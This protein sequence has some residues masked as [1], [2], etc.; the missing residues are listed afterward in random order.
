MVNVSKFVRDH[1]PLCVCTLGTAILGYLG[2][3]A[4]QWIINKCHKTEEID[5]VAQRT[6]STSSQRVSQSN[7]HD[8]NPQILPQAKVATQSE[9]VPVDEISLTQQSEDQ[10]PLAATKIQNAFRGHLARVALKQMQFE[11]LERQK[12]TATIKIQSVF[13]AHLAQI[14]FKNE[15]RHLLSYSLY[16]QAKPLIDE[17]EKLR[18]LPTADS[19]RTRVYL[20]NDLPIVLKQSGSPENRKRFDKMKEARKI[21]DDNNYSCLVIPTAR[22]HGNFII[23]SRL[24][25][26]KNHDTKE[27]IGFYLDHLA[28]FTEAVEEFTS[29]LCQSE[30]SD[31]TGG[32]NDAYST[33][34]TVPIGRYDNVAMYLEEGDGKLGLIDL[35][36]FYP[37][38]KS[39]QLEA[40][41]ACREAV[42]LFPHHLDAIINAANKFDPKIESHRKALEEERDYVLEYFKKAYQ[43]HL[44]FVKEKNI[45]L[46]NPIKFDA[47]SLIRKDQIREAI[48]VLI[49]KENNDLRFEN[50]LGETPDVTMKLFNEMAF[51]EIFDYTQKFITDLLKDQLEYHVGSTAISSYSKLISARTLEFSYGSNEYEDL[52]RLIASK[53]DMLTF[54]SKFKKTQFASEIV[55]A[56]LK[57]LEKGKE[58]AY[59]NPSF[60]VGGHA[61][62]C[63]FC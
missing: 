30:L 40:F 13:R 47:I 3:H 31:I 1:I 41:F 37:K 45:D 50:C 12:L 25:I 48:E 22:I 14:A 36:S 32:T 6:I 11:K 55:Y 17:S 39:E 49:Q 61:K 4:V 29:F 10:K 56:I 52:K 62:H 2:Y 59:Y 21:C 53:L 58:I 33:L 9:E 19:G 42:R 57:E 51:P 60:G 28:Q 54:T 26:R 23:E 7:D 5:L 16:E 43:N 15:K 46:T 63:I 44:D 20:L 27:Q 8:T 38:S 24:P 18:D 35:E 34:S